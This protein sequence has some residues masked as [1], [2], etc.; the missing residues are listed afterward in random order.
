[1]ATHDGNR[2]I[3][4]FES[5][6]EVVRRTEAQRQLIE[7]GDKQ[8]RNHIGNLNNYQFDLDGCL[9]TVYTLLYFHMVRYR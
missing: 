4:S 6:T 1:L 2:L 5:S 9:E 8:E 3:K 7:Q